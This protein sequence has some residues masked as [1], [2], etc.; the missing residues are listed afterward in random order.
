MS[1]PKT[2]E[3]RPETPEDVKGIQKVHNEAYEREAEGLLVNAL[4]EANRFVPEMSLVAVEGNRIIG[5]ALFSDIELKTKEKRVKTA[6]L[7]PMAVHPRKQRKGIGKQLVRKG[8]ETL[9]NL[10]YEVV[11]V[12]GDRRYYEQFGFSADVTWKIRSAHKG[13]HFLGLELKKGALAKFPEWEAVYPN[14]FRIVG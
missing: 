14:E 10:G 5:H 11:L 2:V 3:I 1:S 13:P 8:L 4:R 12:Y 9:R 7:A 6:A